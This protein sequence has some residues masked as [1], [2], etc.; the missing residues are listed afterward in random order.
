MLIEKLQLIR[1][2]QLR[3][4]IQRNIKNSQKIIKTNNNNIVHCSGT[5]NFLFGMSHAE[6]SSVLKTL[7][8]FVGTRAQPKATVLGR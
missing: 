3:P 4:E 6:L 2:P 7:F 8:H 5:E 1:V